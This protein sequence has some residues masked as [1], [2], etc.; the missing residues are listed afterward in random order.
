MRSILVPGFQKGQS[1][2]CGFQKGGALLR[3]LKGQ[4]PLT[5]IKIKK[6]LT[7]LTTKTTILV[8][9]PKTETTRKKF[10]TTLKE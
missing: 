2:F 6:L 5:I 3:D 7:I 8:E 9:L 10:L 1:P 4:S